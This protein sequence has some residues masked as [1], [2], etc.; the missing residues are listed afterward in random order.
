MTVQ[1]TY[2]F[3]QPRAYAGLQ[4]DNNPVRSISPYAESG[5]IPFGRAVQVGT[6]E[7]QAV[8][9]TGTG[10]YLGITMRVHNEENVAAGVESAQY[11]DKEPMAVMQE[12]TIFISLI[13]TGSKGDPIYSVDVDGTIGAG[14]AV[15]GQT[16]IPGGELLE[17][18]TV[19]DTIVP[20]RLKSE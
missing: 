8:I 11:T 6:D 16:Q 5:P 14:T 12:G 4:A 15:A 17:T 13:N 9:G 1:L 10:L 7:D 18:V 20:I 2:E 3:K 19:V